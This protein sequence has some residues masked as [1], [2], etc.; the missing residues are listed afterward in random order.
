MTLVRMVKLAFI[1]GVLCAVIA[2]MSTLIT[3]NVSFGSPEQSGFR[4]NVHVGNLSVAK[5]LGSVALALLVMSAVL[6]VMSSKQSRQNNKEYS[7]N[8]FL[9]TLHRSETDCKI[10]GVCGGLAEGSPIPSWTWRMLFLVLAFYYGT[11]VLPYVILWMCL[12]VRR[13]QN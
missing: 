1:L 11:G 12:P 2:A 3:L 6:S 7:L 8:D 5:S 9:K 4:F 13:A 10:A